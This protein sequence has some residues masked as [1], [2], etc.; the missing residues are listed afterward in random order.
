MKH[1][2]KHHLQNIHVSHAG[3][4]IPADPVRPYPVPSV[5]APA[6]DV[7]TDVKVAPVSDKCFSS[8]FTVTVL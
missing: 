3:N 5:V 4:H 7:S 2:E 8:I 1:R 6:P